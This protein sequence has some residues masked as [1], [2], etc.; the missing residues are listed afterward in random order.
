MKKNLT[1]KIVI[2]KKENE[3]EEF[4]MA[5]AQCDKKHPDPT[6]NVSSKNSGNF[7]RAWQA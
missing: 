1:N 2:K 3:S 7:F 6:I 5:S 4:R